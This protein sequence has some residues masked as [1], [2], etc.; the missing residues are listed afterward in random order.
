MTHLP[1]SRAKNLVKTPIQVDKIDLLTSVSGNITATSD[2]ING[3]V[4][5]IKSVNGNFT[6]SGRV[7]VN[8]TSPYTEQ[9]ASINLLSG[10]FTTTIASVPVVG[11][12][13]AVMTAQDASK[14]GSIYVYY[15]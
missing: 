2:V 7:L 4:V 12:V 8:S 6:T 14:S 3:L 11:T 13:Q 15:Y 5:A 1:T 9:L 10:G